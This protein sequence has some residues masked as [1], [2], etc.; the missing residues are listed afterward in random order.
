MIPLFLCCQYLLCNPNCGCVLRSR[1]FRPWFHGYQISIPNNQLFSDYHLTSLHPPLMP[2]LLLLWLDEFSFS[3]P[4]LIEILLNVACSERER[5]R[6]TRRFRRRANRR[7][8]NQWWDTNRPT[9]I[10]K[11]HYTDLITSTQMHCTLYFLFILLVLLCLSLSEHATFKSISIRIG[12]E[13]ENSSSHSRRR[14][15]RRGG[16]SEVRW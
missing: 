6:R 4:I 3:P 5:Q 16:W 9:R 13:N 2:G 12:G 10:Y 15:G 14:L 1:E 7:K 11:R 8:I